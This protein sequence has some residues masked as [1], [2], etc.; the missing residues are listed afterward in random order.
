[1]S[2]RGGAVCKGLTQWAAANLQCATRAIPALCRMA[3]RTPPDIHPPAA[4]S[5]SLPPSMSRDHH[6]LPSDLLEQLFDIA[7]ATALE[8]MASGMAHE[9]NQSL[10]AIATFSQAGERMLQRSEPMV[11]EAADVLRQI[12]QQAMAAGE[13]LRRI[14]RLFDRSHGQ[15][16]VLGLNDL[17]Q[18]IEPVLR[19]LAERAGVRLELH[20]APGLPRVSVESRQ[21]QHVLFMLV[22]NAVE[23]SRGHGSTPRVDIL[24][25]SD[26]YSVETAIVDS[27]PGI[28]SDI[29]PRLFL[30]FFTTKPGG[31]GLGLASS[32]TIMEAHGGSVG[33]DEAPS[34]GTRFW[35]RLPVTE[36]NGRGDR[37]H[38]T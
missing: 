3:F 10:G 28:P 11:S 12:S 22:Q 33:F 31:T 16:V 38:T 8:E 25:G 9:L 29:R 1:M 5:L 14:R 34:G 24:T 37:G 30:P 19:L 13:G 23:A 32:R 35:L 15:R 36:S 7:R 4:K 2:S 20:L 26:G 27:G 17:I 18:E 21:I 6:P